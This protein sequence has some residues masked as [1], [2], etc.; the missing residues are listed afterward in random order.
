MYYENAINSQVK[1][2]KRMLYRKIND[3][4][5]PKIKDEKFLTT[6]ADK[7]LPMLTSCHLRESTFKIFIAFYLMVNSLTSFSQACG[8]P[9]PADCA[10]NLIYQMFN[11]NQHQFSYNTV[12]CTDPIISVIWYIDND[13]YAGEGNPKIIEFPA[14]GTYS[15]S[16][17][18]LFES[19]CC[20]EKSITI[21]VSTEDV[22]DIT[23]SP[24]CSD[25]IINE[26]F[27][28]TTCVILNNSN[29][30][31]EDCI[32]SWE[33]ASGTPDLFLASN[34]NPA[35]DGNVYAYFVINEAIYKPQTFRKNRNYKLNFASN[36]S[37]F[38]G[39]GSSQGTMNVYLANGLTPYTSPPGSTENFPP[40]YASSLNTIFPLIADMP[41]CYLNW[42]ENCYSF[43]IN[44]KP[45]EYFQ[46]LFHPDLGENPGR[47]A[48]ALDKVKL[49]CELDILKT[50]GFIANVMDTKVDFSPDLLI[51]NPSGTITYMWDFG[52]GSQTN[53][54]NVSHTYL[55]GGDYLVTLDIVDES[56]CCQKIS[57]IVKVKCYDISFTIK[58]SICGTYLFD[59]NT[60][61]QGLRYSWTF[62]PGA[63]STEKS[64]EYSFHKNGEYIV[65][66]KVFNSLGIL[67]CQSN[68]K[69]EIL[70]FP[71][72]PKC[73]DVDHPIR[74]FI[75]GLNSTNSTTHHDDFLWSVYCKQNGLDP[76]NQLRTK[77]FVRGTLIIDVNCNFE[78]TEWIMDE[79]A[80]IIAKNKVEFKGLDKLT[81]CEKMWKG[82]TLE[83]S[84]NKFKL[85]K[86]YDADKAIY[87]SKGNRNSISECEFVNNAYGIYIDGNT[88]PVVFPFIAFRGNTLKGTGTLKPSYLGQDLISTNYPHAGIYASNTTTILVTGSSLTNTFENMIHGILLNGSNV[89]SS[90][91][92]YKNL[93]KLSNSELE[94]GSGIYSLNAKNTSVTTFDTYLESRNGV[95]FRNSSILSKISVFN[96]T[97]KNMT[98]SGIFVK[99]GCTNCEITIENNKD[100]KENE[101]GIILSNITTPK[102]VR[103][104]K[105]KQLIG[106]RTSIAVENSNG[107]LNMTSIF[108]N[109][110]VFSDLSQWGIRLSNAKDKWDVKSNVLDMTTMRNSDYYG[111]ISSNSSNNIFENNIVEKGNLFARNYDIFSSNDNVIKCNKS[112]NANI[113]FQFAG[114]CLGTNFQANQMNSN[115]AGLK[116]EKAVISNMST[117]NG[118][119]S[120]QEYKGNSWDGPNSKAVIEDGSPTNLNAFIYNSSLTNPAPPSSTA[121]WKPAITVRLNPDNGLETN[122]ND[123]FDFGSNKNNQTCS[124]T[125]PPPTNS[126]MTIL[127]KVID[128]TLLINEYTQQNAWTGQWQLLDILSRNIQLLNSYDKLA[129][130]YNDNSVVKSYYLM[131]KSIDELSSINNSDES[132]LEAIEQSIF[133]IEQ[134]LITYA[135]TEGNNLTTN[136]ANAKIDVI[137]AQVIQAKILHDQH[138]NNVQNLAFSLLQELESLPEPY[139]FCKDYKEVFKARLNLVLESDDFVISTH[140]V[141]LKRIAE[142][143][144][145][146]V[147][148][149]VSIAQGLCR[150][151]GISF[152]EGD[153]CSRNRE[154]IGDNKLSLNNS[155]VV[156]PNPVSKE[157]E[158]NSIKL[159]NKYTILDVANH[160]IIEMKVEEAN[161]LY[162]E[163][164]NYLPGIYFINVRHND[165][166]V[167]SAKFIKI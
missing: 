39:T 41:L 59:V 109:K 24:L 63:T 46:L 114:I 123:W 80:E 121:F 140:R 70:C 113:G 62:N 5:R 128:G 139:S 40:A 66:L 142:S 104:D 97:I 3:G 150:S 36:V 146:D 116:I 31:Q 2:M 32:D 141:N 117:E 85:S 119:I 30:F 58:N 145:Y 166:S 60:Q 77:F 55:T 105:N 67:I 134:E 1:T 53:G 149:P 64:P 45:E 108:D 93:K 148:K 34:S 17:T 73:E 112:I 164:A 87:F 167:S 115:L 107:K 125:I 147:G 15:I 151:L 155:L 156:S 143:C 129:N 75:S 9:C 78:G 22:I 14:S 137:Q 160:K 111:I 83:Q 68:A 23:C 33:C 152:N 79:G 135:D 154:R 165:G 89:L 27:E 94:T 81:G 37:S 102:K 157:I 131:E 10:G 25:F 110:I 124:S 51:A 95:Y 118:V 127:D 20:I 96:N 158:V 133:Q 86:I 42:T 162:I 76:L 106:N 100:I 12:N 28:N 72:I 13:I 122:I 120:V 56:G 74:K 8:N 98:Y 26:S 130:F 29:Q 82:I 163:I 16:G 101:N 84:S 44:D 138:L 88:I 7:L 103:I 61:D 132:N 54:Q 6:I 159:F 48:A 69:I 38:K 11:C 92:I 161:R 43:N 52:D 50:E 65:N 126:S 136:E 19:G 35:Y 153:A 4:F 49:T 71:P 47:I 18:I 21:Q 91:N 90:Y 99:D 144:K 57:K